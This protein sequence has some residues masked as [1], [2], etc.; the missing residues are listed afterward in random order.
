MGSIKL[1]ALSIDKMFVGNSEVDKV[2][3]G[4]TLVYESQ[5]TPQPTIDTYLT[6]SSPNSFTLNVADN[7]KYWD[8]TLEYSTDKTN[9]STWTG[10]SAISSASDGT[11]HNLYLRGTGNT[12]IT[13]SVA[14]SSAG[15]WRLNGSNISVSGNIENLLDYAT[16]ELGNHPPMAGGVFKVLFAY[17]SSSPNGNI[18][19]ISQLE[20]PTTTLI[21]DCYRGMFQA[22][23]AITTAPELPAT[24]LA[25]NCYYNMF[26]SCTSLTTAPNLPATTL[27]SQCYE[28]MFSGCTALTT[29]PALP[30]TTLAVN[31]Y[32]GMFYNC[33]ALTTAPALPATTLA[34]NCYYY[35]FGDC[36]NIKL[37]T[38][39]DIIYT[40]SYRIPSSGTGTTGT[41]SLVNMFSNTGGSFTGTPTINT[42]YYTSNTVIPAGGNN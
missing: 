37:S 10:T 14:G 7:L 16:V 2:Y 42:T 12:K 8:G 25:V 5:S 13:G 1:G 29:A 30:A 40:N 23:S 41:N 20:L 18:T 33:K 36:S 26:N 22:L 4:D 27:T 39:Q 38:T 21:T 19:D 35:M 31:C 17:P 11:K 32:Y 34:D 24:T 3:I 28:Y 15:A 9:W 6:F